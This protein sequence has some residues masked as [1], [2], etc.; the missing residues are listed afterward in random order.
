MMNFIH[1]NHDSASSKIFFLLTIQY[2]TVL[3]NILQDTY[4]TLT[5]T[6][7]NRFFFNKKELLYLQYNA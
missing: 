7:Y 1:N 4:T 6:T 2:N 3:N 5:C